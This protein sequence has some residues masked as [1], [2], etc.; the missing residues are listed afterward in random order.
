M[1]HPP[2][3]AL[4]DRQLLAVHEVWRNRNPTFN[5]YLLS[6]FRTFTASQDIQTDLTE[7][8]KGLAGWFGI[9]LAAYFSV[10]IFPFFFPPSTP[11]LSASYSAGFNNKVASIAAVLIG[12]SSFAFAR[13][14]HR[15]TGML[16]VSS[17]RLPTRLLCIALVAYASTL[18]LNSAFVYAFPHSY[19]EAAY[20]L[21]RIDQIALFGKTPFK[22][23]EF[24][25]GPLLLYAPVLVHW[26]GAPLHI[27]VEWSY[28]ICLTVFSLIGVFALF[29]LVNA[30]VPGRHY[31]SVAFGGLALLG[32]LN[33]SMGMNYMYFRFVGP[34]VA[35]LIAERLNTVRKTVVFLAI[36]SLSLFSVSPEI[37]L[38]FAVGASGLSICRCVM[39]GRQWLACLVAAWVGPACLI[40]VFGPRYLQTFSAFSKGAQNFVVVPVAHILLFLIALVFIIPIGAARLPLS[41]WR[42]HPGL[43]GILLSSF[44]LVPA[45]LGRCDVG[46]VF[47]N[48]IGIILLS[49]SFAFDY[50]RPARNLWLGVV[51][52]VFFHSA[53][54]GLHSYARSGIRVAAAG[55]GAY[56]PSA[57]SLLV[58]LIPAQL[59]GKLIESRAPINAVL[60]RDRV[61]KS[62]VAT[63]FGADKQMTQ[64]LQG[65]NL[66]TP[67]FF[68]GMTNVFDSNAENQSINDL[69][70]QRW[71]LIPRDIYFA[72]ENIDFVRWLFS[73]PIRYRY[74]RAPYQPG[75]RLLAHVEH[76]WDRGDSIGGFRLYCNK[77]LGPC[78][79]QF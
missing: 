15:R 32:L 3:S 46:H 73:S 38:A 11:S 19:G 2:A 35:L 16:F 65:S 51:F 57:G 72:D 48:G 25:Y 41:H 6:M 52:V 68:S 26:L 40:T 8:L 31:K 74:L 50:G 34:C 12:L 42:E 1:L 7:R 70:K 58:E 27:S 56:I 43:L 36:A 23:F 29:E 44:F 9:G 28:Y 76:L 33:P 22:D 5:P 37:G 24:A 75:K 79:T 61:G 71:A 77:R 53:F 69:D 54:T 47:Y 67:S 17:Y 45:A 60:L 55:I 63:P 66:Y 18:A 39:D 20:F 62:G 14:R 21:N 30:L 4:P 13:R 49:L 10:F 78:P 59:R 64:Q